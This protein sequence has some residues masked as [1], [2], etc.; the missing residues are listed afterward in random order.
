MDINSGALKELLESLRLMYGYDFTGY[1][2][3]SLKRRILHFMNLNKI[4]D[5]EKLSKLLLQDEKCF[6]LLVQEISVTVTEMFRDADFYKALREHVTKRLA[7]YP[8]IKI[9]IAG[10]ATGEEVYSVAIILKEEGLLPRSVIYATDINQRSLKTAREGI[11]PVSRMKEYT[12]NYQKSGG[13]DEF[14]AYY[15][16]KYDA[17]LIDKSLKQNIVFASHN[18]ATDKSFSEFQLI[19]CRNVLIYF[20]QALQNLVLNLFYESLCI[21]GYLG[22]GSKESLLSSEKQKYFEDVSRKNK[23]FM[24]IK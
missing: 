14:S 9:W 24:K 1:A 23:L 16:T 5:I 22:L 10:C 12:A 19:L 6:E 18:L 2:E 7:T 17:V 15:T 13:T 8:F 3:A 4:D 21:F 20:N 11:Y